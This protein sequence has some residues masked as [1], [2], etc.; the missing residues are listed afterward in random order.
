MSGSCRRGPRDLTWTV[1]GSTL[2]RASGS[3]AAAHP[4][5]AAHVVPIALQRV[6]ILWS[7]ST[8]GSQVTSW[9]NGQEGAADI[10]GHL[11]WHSCAPPGGCE[12]FH[13]FTHS[14]W[15]LPAL[16][17]GSPS[18]CRGLCKSRMGLWPRPSYGLNWVPSNSFVEVL[19][20]SKYRG[21]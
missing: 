11:K 5:S 13:L 10:L 6:F 12:S 19:M 17:L 18:L 1:V 15:V 9:E 2:R 20:P 14:T 8:P 4:S 16:A 21:L 7:L 3:G